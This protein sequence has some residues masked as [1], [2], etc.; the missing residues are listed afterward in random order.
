MATQHE[1]GEMRPMRGV[2]LDN[3]NP[4]LIAHNPGSNFALD[5]VHIDRPMRLVR[6]TLTT[7]QTP[8]SFTG[9]TLTLEI[10]R[11]GVGTGSAVATLPG[12]L[13]PQAL[14]PLAF[15]LPPSQGAYLLL[16]AQDV[17][18]LHVVQSGSATGD[19]PNGYLRL[20][21]VALR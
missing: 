6:A 18:I 14:Q 17:L 21:L 1:K 3:G 12:T 19:L 15:N 10:E 5:V 11:N 16:Q 4:T 2:R 8:S 7:D 13:Y 20:D 9:Y